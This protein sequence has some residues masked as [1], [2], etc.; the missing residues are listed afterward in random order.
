MA[1]IYFTSNADSGDGSLRWAITQ[2]QPGDVIRPDESVFDRGSIIEIVL[3]S[4]LNVDKNL[5][6]DGGPFRVRLNG[7]GAVRGV[8]VAGEAVATITAFDF[9]ACYG[10]SSGGGARM[11]ERAQA[12]FNRCFFAGCDSTYGGGIAVQ[13][14][15]S[16]TLNDCAVVGC[17]ATTNYGG[18]IYAS[19]DVVLNGV[20]VIGCASLQKSDVLLNTGVL[21]VARNSIVGK[22][23]R[24]NSAEPTFES[25]V[26]NVASSDVGFVASPPDDLTVENW[27]ANAWQ[28]W[29]LRLLDDA[30]GA[31]SPYRDSGDVGAMSRYDLDGNFR[32]RET[33][34]VATCS[35]GA[36]ETIQ[37]DLFWVGRD[38]TGAEVVAPSFLTSDGWA[39]SRFATVAGDVAPQAGQTLFVDG[40]V[41]FSDFASTERTRPVGLTVGGGAVVGIV[42]A[43]TSY[44][45][46]LQVGACAKLTSS[47][48]ITTT[49]PRLGARS[50][51][52]GLFTIETYKIEAYENSRI[53]A[54]RVFHGLAPSAPT[55]GTLTVYT[56]TGSAARLNGEY[57]CDVFATLQNGTATGQRIVIGDE[58]AS[59]RA[60]EFRLG[61][62]D[63]ANYVNNFFDRAVTLKLQGD[64]VV[65]TP[66][67][68]LDDW[69]DDFVID[70]TEATSATLTLGGQTIYGDAP[71][72]AVALTGTA[73]IDERD[74]TAQSLALNADAALNVDGGRVCVDA[75][76]L[77]ASS[78]VVSGGRVDVELLTVADGANVVFA[79]VNGDAIVSVNDASIGTASFTGIGYLASSTE[80][81]LTATTVDE[82]VRVCD[83]GADIQ[84]F[85]ATSVG[86]TVTLRWSANDYTRGV[87]VEILDNNEWLGTSVFSTDGSL[88]FESDSAGDVTFRVFDGEKFLQTTVYVESF[89]AWLTYDNLF[90]SAIVVKSYTVVT[91]CILMSSY[92]NA[93]E[94]PVLLARIADSLTNV[95]VTPNDV[96][97]ISLTVYKTQLYRGV[98]QRVVLE[99][100]GD[101]DV[102]LTAVMESLIVDDPR[103]KKDSVGYNFRYEPDLRDKPL[104][105]ES[106]EYVVVVTIKFKEGNP[107]PLVFNV[108][109]K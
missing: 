30:S 36:Y 45:D 3:A 59:I 2:A 75:L 108:S 11:N 107:A 15:G 85:S 1:I 50:W 64:A 73:R 76:T 49:L 48:N 104:F 40:V 39:A 67:N 105:N 106:G 8:I 57:T 6:L 26:V 83:Y 95:A 54:A 102:P 51:F 41:S 71:T 12:T 32:G 5:T 81:D 28:N 62:D 34:G 56:V 94:A 17:R 43:S 89:H 82:T 84:S 46:A 53:E 19:G 101:V 74:L 29:D 42:R 92:F 80:I 70:V 37:A 14:G 88:V 52:Y 69:A 44:L 24:S 86:K 10:S 78:L 60:R 27:N 66:A 97:S 96:E 91:E 98:K 18:G 21:L 20:T 23:M 4:A 55:Y 35:P 38:A 72:C 16:A 61:G 77:G 47:N 63:A 100:W 90:T 103:W 109:V 93:G 25:C 7:G 87:L 99:G 22:L 9:I 31:P 65:S 79:N 68:A 33:N 58:G 13:K